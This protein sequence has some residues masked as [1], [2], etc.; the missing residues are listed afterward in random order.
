MPEP[1][2]RQVKEE[3]R[4]AI[5]YY[6]VDAFD[7]FGKV[8]KLKEFIT[9]TPTPIDEIY[10]QD[11]AENPINFIMVTENN[12]EGLRGR[13]AMTEV[14]KGIDGGRATFNSIKDK[15]Y[16]N[17]KNLG[18]GELAKK[19][20]NQVNEDYIYSGIRKY[21][22]DSDEEGYRQR[23]SYWVRNLPEEKAARSEYSKQNNKENGLVW[24]FIFAICFLAI[25]GI[26]SLFVDVDTRTDREKAQ[27]EY[28]ARLGRTC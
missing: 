7:R 19:A 28:C 25:S 15:I 9:S 14:L 27:S 12:I 23:L 13:V 6:A 10:E 20:Y 24:I 17:Y 22:I 16:E 1:T 4:F 5:I 11:V 2:L 18:H 3:M 8:N 26:V 21:G